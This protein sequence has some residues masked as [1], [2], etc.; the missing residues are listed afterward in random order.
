MKILRVVEENDLDPAGWVV[1]KVRHDLA[2]RVVHALE[3]AQ[4]LRRLLPRDV[5]SQ[6]E[7][8]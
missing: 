1:G 2:E 5:G 7:V 4:L 6:D 8:R 3:L